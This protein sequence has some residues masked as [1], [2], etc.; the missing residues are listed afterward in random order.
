MVPPFILAFIENYHIFLKDSA[1]TLSPICMSRPEP[2]LCKSK[3]YSV[4][5][6]HFPDGALY[7]GA[8]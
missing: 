3:Q 6:Q 4:K 8:A 7:E 1:K 5:C 2:E